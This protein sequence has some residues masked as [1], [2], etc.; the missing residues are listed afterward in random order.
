VRKRVKEISPTQDAALARATMRIV[1]A[2]L[3]AARGGG[4]SAGAGGGGTGQDAAAAALAGGGQQ[5]GGDVDEGAEPDAPKNLAANSWSSSA[6]A[7]AAA[8][9]S[10]GA[11]A[12]LDEMGRSRLLEAAFV[13]GL[14]W[15]VGGSTDSEGRREFDAFLR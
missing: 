12:G 1:G 10:S 11:L 7:A 13:F 8:G 2:L 9:G 3:G 14:V 15:G 4:A 5:K 6:S